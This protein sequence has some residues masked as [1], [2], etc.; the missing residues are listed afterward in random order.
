MDDLRAIETFLNA[1][2]HYSADS[3]KGS[4][5]HQVTPQALVLLHYAQERTRRA[6]KR[7][8]LLS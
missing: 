7:L 2:E 1:I 3:Q 5:V 6:R 4:D 8:D